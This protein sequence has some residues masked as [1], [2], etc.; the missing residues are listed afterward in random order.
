V[1]ASL[2]SSLPPITIR[3]APPVVYVTPV[4]FFAPQGETCFASGGGFAESRTVQTEVSDS[5]VSEHVLRPLVL[6]SVN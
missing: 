3:L 4:G 1:R 2:S 6:V 5:I